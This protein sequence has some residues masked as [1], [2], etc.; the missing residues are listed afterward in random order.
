MEVEVEK[1]LR[2]RIRGLVTSVI[3]QV[4]FKSGFFQ[5]GG[6]LVLVPNNILY[7][8]KLKTKT[9]YTVNFLNIF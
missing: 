7:R 4:S 9:R 3:F 5:E 1:R 8:T 2:L 6:G